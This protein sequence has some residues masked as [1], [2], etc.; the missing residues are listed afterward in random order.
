MFFN[1]TRGGGLGDNDIYQSY[2]DNVNDDFGWQAPTNLGP[3]VNS[4]VNDNGPAYFENSGAPQL[5]FGSGCA[6]A[7][8]VSATCSSASFGVNA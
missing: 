3:N 7:A 6:Q 8:S 4:P 2:R 5:F 1:S